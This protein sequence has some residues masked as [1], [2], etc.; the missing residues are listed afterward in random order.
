MQSTVLL[1]QYVSLSV[2]LSVSWFLNIS[3]LHIFLSLVWRFV[4]V[5]N[6]WCREHR[7]VQS[8]WCW[9]RM[10]FVYSASLPLSF[11]ECCCRCHVPILLNVSFVLLWLVYLSDNIGLSNFEC[12]Q[13]SATLHTLIIYFKCEN[14]FQALQRYEYILI[15]RFYINICIQFHQQMQTE[16]AIVSLW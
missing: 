1:Q 10:H 4:V 7:V 2:C 8:C 5:T 13:V 12:I 9:Q 6:N 3:L 14:I 15:Y 11:R 16:K